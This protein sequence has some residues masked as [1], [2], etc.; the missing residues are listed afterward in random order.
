MERDAGAYLSEVSRAW[1]DVPT[2]VLTPAFHLEGRYPT[3]PESCFADVARITRDAAAR[4][5]QMTVVD[6]EWLL[7]PE[8][9]FLIDASDH[10]GP[11]GQV[12][13]YEEVRRQVMLL[14]G[15]SAS[16]EA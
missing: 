8:P 4:H 3:H 12:A 1:P 2:L 5:P 14:P 9:S 7:P 6:G 13:F 15:R 16:S 11:N 10:P